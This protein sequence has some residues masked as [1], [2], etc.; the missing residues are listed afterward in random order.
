M[1]QTHLVQV[2]HVLEPGNLGRAEAALDPV[3]ARDGATGRGSDAPDQG[4]IVAAAC[5]SRAAA[6]ELGDGAEP[7]ADSVA[8]GFGLSK[9]LVACAL[10]ALV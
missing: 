6:L 2:V 1:L 9:G 10:E 8:D 5:V 4:P 3:A 7:G